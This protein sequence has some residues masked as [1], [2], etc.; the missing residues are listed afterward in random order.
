MD[1]VGPA[2]AKR[3]PDEVARLDSELFGPVRQSASSGSSAVGV[4]RAHR[5]GLLPRL[6]EDAST[7]VEQW[8]DQARVT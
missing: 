2:R 8:T 5:H 4:V 3:I 1:L 6:L 7:S